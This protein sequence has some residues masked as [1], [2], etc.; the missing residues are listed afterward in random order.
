MIHLTTSSLDHHPHC[1][2]PC[3]LSFIFLY[4]L[5]FPSSSLSMSHSGSLSGSC[6]LTTYSLSHSCLIISTT[7]WSY[8]PSTHQMMTSSVAG[9]K[10]WWRVHWISWPPYS[11]WWKQHWLSHASFSV[12]STHAS[13]P[14]PLHSNHLLEQ[15]DSKPSRWPFLENPEFFSSHPLC[16]LVHTLSIFILIVCVAISQKHLLLWRGCCHIC[17][18]W[19]VSSLLPLIWMR[20]ICVLFHLGDM[21]D[22]DWTHCDNVDSVH[23]DIP[24]LA[25]S[26]VNA[27]ESCSICTS[28]YHHSG[29]AGGLDILYQPHL[30][31]PSL[32]NWPWVPH[33]GIQIQSVP[34]IDLPMN[35]S[36][37]SISSHE[38][39][40]SLHTAHMCPWWIITISSGGRWSWQREDSLITKTSHCPH[41]LITVE[42]WCHI[43]TVVTCCDLNHLRK[44]NDVVSS[45]LAMKVCVLLLLS[46][47]LDIVFLLEMSS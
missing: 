3:K 31:W 10:A 7:R 25:D 5:D 24:K 32:G 21:G 47:W 27:M 23:S 38:V 44:E 17:C 15:G 40:V 42:A 20:G 30:V 33:M 14:F 39:P 35:G 41:L 12:T 13:W 26:D 1:M 11:V 8:G 16:C 28:S 6:F 46:L 45:P 34:L 36:F 18:L 43:L 37:S 2:M 4:G 29:H 22:C 9:V 19:R